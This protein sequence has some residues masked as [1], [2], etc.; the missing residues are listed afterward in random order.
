MKKLKPQKLKKGDT[1]GIISPSGSVRYLEKFE[2]AEEYFYKQ[3]F[4][5]KIFTSA[6]NQN[7]YLAGTDKERLKDFEAAFLDEEVNAILT[8]RGG[9]GAIKI[10]NQINYDIIKNNP[11]IFCGYS[12]ITAY[13]SAIYNKTG[14]ITFHAPFALFDFGAEEIDSYTE[15]NFFNNLSQNNTNNKLK[16]AFDYDC[17]N[18]GNVTGELIGGNLCTIL[19]LIGSSFEPSW[20]NKILFIEDVNEPL[21]KIDRM[22]SQLKLI[23]VFDKIKG[24]LVG[25]FSSA[26]EIFHEKVKELLKEFEIP[27]GYGFSATHELAK[28]TLPLNIEYN[29]DFKTG[30]VIITEEYLE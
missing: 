8:S 25:K 20:Q 18:S 13:H 19:S 21:Y 16:N 1:I 17:I 26:D 12:D 24:L 10:L 11:K 14:L 28:N 27:C 29:I 23:G 3:G 2:K 30:N 4:K 6:K 22:L 9:Y 5:T 7:D 15:E